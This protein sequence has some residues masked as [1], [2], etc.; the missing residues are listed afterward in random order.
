MSFNIRVVKTR[1]EYY[2]VPISEDRE[3]N[4][5]TS[6][7]TSERKD[8]ISVIDIYMILDP[9]KVQEEEIFL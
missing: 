4:D 3:A 1:L 7:M 6:N 9:E 2:I 5:F 8:F